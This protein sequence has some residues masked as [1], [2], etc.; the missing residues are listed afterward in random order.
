[1]ESLCERVY[2]TIEQR[3]Q[4]K[5]KIKQIGLTLEKCNKLYEI[6]QTMTFL[7]KH[8]VF[9]AM[10]LEL[11]EQL[12]NEIIVKF[13]FLLIIIACFILFFGCLF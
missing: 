9:T 12:A 4:L 1:M 10:N 5:Q 3:A 8:S 7:L 2:C 13:V 11:V 6:S